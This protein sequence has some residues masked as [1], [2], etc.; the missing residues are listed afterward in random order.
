MAPVKDIECGLRPVAL[1]KDIG[2]EVMICSS[3]KE[4]WVSDGSLWPW[5][6]ILSVG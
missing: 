5:S 6:R 3:G 4:Y 1:I 2:C